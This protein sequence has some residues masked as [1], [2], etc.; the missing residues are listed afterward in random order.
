M[1]TMSAPTPMDA[2]GHRKARMH[3]RGFALCAE[4]VWIWPRCA[5]KKIRRWLAK[6][7]HVRGGQVTEKPGIAG[8]SRAGPAS[9]ALPKM[10]ALYITSVTL[11]VQFVNKSCLFGSL[12]ERKLPY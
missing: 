3:A 6:G 10:S 8:L 4:S 5:L 2:I 7:V 9:D 12:I 1:E 11:Q